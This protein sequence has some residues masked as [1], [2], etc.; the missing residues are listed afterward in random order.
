MSKNN[1]SNRPGYLYMDGVAE[2]DYVDS[3]EE[4]RGAITTLKVFNDGGA[5]LEFAINREEDADSV[6]GVVPAGESVSLDDIDQGLNSIA[7]RG[8]GAFRVWAYH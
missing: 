8:S 5:D 7:V 3:R 1:V 6:D 2:A 4:V